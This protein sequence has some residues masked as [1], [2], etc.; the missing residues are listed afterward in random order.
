MD[1]IDSVCFCGPHSLL[2]DESRGWVELKGEGEVRNAGSTQR[3]VGK[4]RSKL[5]GDLEEHR[6]RGRAGGKATGR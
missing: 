1:R 4:E 3:R 6:G 5:G 2:G